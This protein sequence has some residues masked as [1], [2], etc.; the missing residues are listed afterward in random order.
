MRGRSWAQ[1]LF[2]SVRSLLTGR[3]VRDMFRPALHLSNEC[4]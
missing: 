2:S 4:A 1:P 3:I